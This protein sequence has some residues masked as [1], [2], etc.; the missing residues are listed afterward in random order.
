MAADRLGALRAIQPTGPYRLGGFCNG[1]VLA[2]EMAR[3]LQSQGESVE[4]LL[5]VDSRALNAP[6]RYRLLSRVIRHI[7]G[8]LHWSDA[9]RRAFFLRLRLFLEVYSDSARPG[10]RGRA[11]FLLDKACTV[12]RRS[13][14]PAAPDSAAEEINEHSPLR[15][16]YGQ[17]LRVYV[18]GRYTGRIALFRSSHLIGKPPGSHASWDSSLG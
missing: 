11:R 8:S 6:L 7:A 18:P 15:P 2:F 17:R 13:M 5:L 9:K 10:G 16:E 14:R 3:Q 1:G 12:L 4:T